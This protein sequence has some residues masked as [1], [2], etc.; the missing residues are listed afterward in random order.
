[1][2]RQTIQVWEAPVRILHWTHFFSIT[3]L[4][5]TGLYI[6]YPFIDADDV[7]ATYIMGWV[8]A[9]HFV[10]AFVFVFGFVVR[11]Y[12]FFVG[13]QYEKWLAWIPVTRE[14]W[15]EVIQMLKYYLFLSQERPRY[16]GLDPM[17]G[18]T[19]IAL[20]VLIVVQAITGFAL[21]SLSFRFGVWPALFSWPINLFGAQPVRL[22]HHILLWLFVA[23]FVG[24]IY[25]SVLD[26]IEEHRGE[27]VS[28]ISGD[29]YEPTEGEAAADAPSEAAGQ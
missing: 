1:M 27:F 22:V 11:G 10:A 16:V 20:G 6:G 29:K 28:M 25:L 2:L 18:L 8:R 15:R 3:V 13:N 5:L 19:F 21:F 14:R 26:D 17:A 7:N 23:F 4:A 12:W 9:V 24:H